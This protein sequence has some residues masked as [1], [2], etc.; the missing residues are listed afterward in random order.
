MRRRTFFLC[1]FLLLSF[2]NV[3]VLAITTT[4]TVFDRGYQ[5]PLI[6]PSTVHELGTNPPTGGQFPQSE[7]LSSSYFDDTTYVP[8]AETEDDPQFPNT[9]VEI[10]NLT[11][12]TW[13]SVWYVADVETVLGNED[14][15]ING[16]QAFKI[17]NVGINTPLIYESMIVNNI[18]EPGEIW[19]F[20][21]QDYSNGNL[22]SPADFSSVGVGGLSFMDY[23]SSGSIVAIPAPGAILLCSIGINLVN[24]LRRCKAI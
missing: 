14:G 11:G 2:Y 24:W 7:L 15:W 20:V 12:L 8:C 5:D 1:L 23:E 10:T 3:K 9:V 18:F 13:S 6:V 16:G 4:V 22:L 19:R 21:I 17:D